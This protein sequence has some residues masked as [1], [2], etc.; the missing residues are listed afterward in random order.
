NLRAVLTSS[1]SRDRN[2]SVFARSGAVATC[3]GP[4]PRG[5]CDAPTLIDKDDLEHEFVVG[6]ARV[7]FHRSSARPP[8]A[9][10]LTTTQDPDEAG[11]L[12]RRLLPVLPDQATAP[13]TP[14]S[15][16]PRANV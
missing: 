3:D 10:L 9:I 14:V 8:T 6:V 15:I 13:T 7:G 11:R 16:R 2:R 4:A 5:R 1:Q 12:S